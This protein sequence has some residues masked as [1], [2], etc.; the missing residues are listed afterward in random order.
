MKEN[1]ICCLVSLFLLL[2]DVFGLEMGFYLEKGFG[3]TSRLGFTLLCPPLLC[4]HFLFN[5]NISVFFVF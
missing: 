2:L 1:I 3:R 5:Y 4:F